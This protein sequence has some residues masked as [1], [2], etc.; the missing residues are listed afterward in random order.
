MT[1]GC[2]TYNDPVPVDLMQGGGLFDDMSFAL[3]TAFLLSEAA[4]H[5]RETGQNLSMFSVDQTKSRHATYNVIFFELFGVCDAGGSVPNKNIHTLCVGIDLVAPLH[6]RNSRP[7]AVA[8][9]RR[10]EDTL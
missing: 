1:N 3:K 10:G 2:G 8:K 6:D 9:I 5:H 7:K 4:F